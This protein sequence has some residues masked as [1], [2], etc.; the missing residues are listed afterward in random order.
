MTYCLKVWN[1]PPDDA[2]HNP[3]ISQFSDMPSDTFASIEEAEEAAK[4][5]VAKYATNGGQNGGGY[6][7]ED[8]YYYVRAE[9][10]PDKFRFTQIVIAQC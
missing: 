2:R 1:A 8:D 6:N 3:W 10:A 9:V 5:F 4:A 7:P